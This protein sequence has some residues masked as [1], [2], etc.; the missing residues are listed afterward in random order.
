MIRTHL[1]RWFCTPAS[2]LVLGV[3]PMLMIIWTQKIG[4]GVRTDFIIESAL[5]DAQINASNFH[6]WFEEAL[7]GDPDV[8]FEKTW[9]LLDRARELLTVVLEGGATEHDPV[10]QPLKEPAKRDRVEELMSLLEQL[11]EVGRERQESPALSGIGSTLDTRFDDAFK[12]FMERTR[13]LEME[14]EQLRTLSQTRSKHLF[15]TILLAWFAIVFAAAFG[16]WNLEGKR[17]SAD[18]ALKRANERL[19]A[20]ADELI[21][22]HN[23][24]AALVQERTGELRGVNESLKKEIVERQ[25]IEEE[26]RRS[27]RELQFLSARILTAQE[28]ERGRISRELH[29]ELGQALA[30]LKLR[31]GFIEKRQERE[32]LKAEFKDILG[33]I[34]EV[35]EE[36]RRL[37]RALSPTILEYFGLSAAIKRLVHDFARDRGID[38]SLD[39]VDEFGHLL[40]KHAQIIVYRVFQEAL[41][42]IGKH[43]TATHLL[44]RVERNK[45]G[46]CF[47]LED[48]GNGFDMNRTITTDTDESGLGLAIMHER[49]RMLGGTLELWSEKGKGTRITFHI[50][51]AVEEGV[52]GTLSHCVG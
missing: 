17:R 7:A 28:E 20:Q 37:S 19:Q 32:E 21:L 8:N 16:L 15:W 5:M 41:N 1:P 2:V 49:V 47:L 38:A 18:E 35:L 43:A 33:Y 9:A 11:R 48:N 52:D 31:I 42:N 34:D 29:D 40:P 50:P 24:L 12:L 22:H 25:K 4:E 23:H 10:L 14:V 46:I 13:D 3:L 26:L 6:L 36:T 51:A 30:T 44:V 39:M 27:E 45:G